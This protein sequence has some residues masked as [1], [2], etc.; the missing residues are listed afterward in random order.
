V[1]LFFD[2]NIVLDVLTNREPWVT[3]SATT[4]SLLDHDE[5]DGFIAAH[6]VTTLHY[7]MGRHLDRE[8]ANA[9]MLDLL[10]LFHIVPVDE[11]TLAKALS[12]T[13]PDFEDAVQAVCALNIGADY[14]V[15]RNAS[16]F[17]GLGLHALTPTELLA[18]LRTIGE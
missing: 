6:T 8:R 5:I 12:I 17:H 9:A 15:T 14:V 3:D 18:L 10:N 11:T 2:V 4:L 1:K 7:L 13:A 16:D